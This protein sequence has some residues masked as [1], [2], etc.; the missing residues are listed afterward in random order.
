MNLTVCS[1]YVVGTGS[2]LYVLDRLC[3][4][5]AAPARLQLAPCRPTNGLEVSLRFDGRGQ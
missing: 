5:A 2:Y 1:F 4:G 3:P